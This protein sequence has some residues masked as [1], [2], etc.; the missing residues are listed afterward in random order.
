MEHDYTDAL[1]RMVQEGTLLSRSYYASFG[2]EHA[3]KSVF[4]SKD[5]ANPNELGIHDFISSDLYVD[6]EGKFQD[7]LLMLN[8]KNAREV[9]VKAL[10]RGKLTQEDIIEF[11]KTLL[12]DVYGKHYD[13]IRRFSVKV[14]MFVTVPL[15]RNDSQLDR[16]A[17]ILD[18]PADTKA[19]AF[20][21]AVEFFSELID[22]HPFEDENGRSTRS[23]TNAYLMSHGLNPLLM[24]KKDQERF[25]EVLDIY[26]FT[27]YYGN[28]LAYALL[29]QLKEADRQEL[30]GK[31]AKMDARTDEEVEIRDMLQ[32]Y[33]GKFDVK[34]IAA[35]AERL[36]K[37]GLEGDV[38]K[39]LCGLRLVEKSGA[40]SWITQD[41]LNS[42]NHNLRIGAVHALRHYETEEVV[43]KIR[44][45]AKNDENFLVRMLAVGIL[46]KKGKL[47]AEYAEE[48]IAKE[49]NG[50][51]LSAL[52]KS[53]TSI[54]KSE[55]YTKSAEMLI[56]SGIKELVLRGYQVMIAHGGE[57]RLWRMLNESL[58]KVPAEIVRLMVIELDA[59]KKINM[60]KVAGVLS[61]AAEN[62]EYLRRILL[63]ELSK[64]DSV[65]TGYFGM[66]DRIIR[67]NSSAPGMKAERAYATFIIGREMGYSY[68]ESEYGMKVSEGKSTIENIA[69]LLTYTASLAKGEASTSTLDGLAGSDDKRLNFVEVAEL[70]KL[71]KAGKI[72]SEIVERFCK[73]GDIA[74]DS[75]AG[76]LEKVLKADVERAR[77]GEDLRGI[78]R[79]TGEIRAARKIKS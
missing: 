21:N 23:I 39:A 5:N 40:K 38:C 15:D 37:K 24:N 65:S 69:I 72:D 36:Y 49:T 58:H 48:L 64:S 26:H 52:G 62:N 43:N 2:L 55:T 11:R 76:L 1:E 18:R 7:Y 51:V 63:G 3:V 53:L 8:S 28:F 14:G 44:D 29:L 61:E 77:R 46:E 73:E 70:S 60:P 17:A 6:K 78:A 9:I 10:E 50:R 33:L 34:A 41:A 30:S 27:G 20:I 75:L 35:D 79:G 13:D 54:E 16:I 19:K 45:L 66:L 31:L 56:A 25:G 47:D 4:Y 59:T 68:L 32:I 67:S 71:M 22:L 57:D 42:G 74:S 12:D